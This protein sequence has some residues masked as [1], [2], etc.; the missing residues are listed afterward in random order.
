MPVF[1]K[2]RRGHQSGRELP[3]VGARNQLQVLSKSRSSHCL[4]ISPAP[5]GATLKAVEFSVGGAWSVL[6]YSGQAFEDSPH[7]W[8]QSILSLPSLPLCEKSLPRT[9]VAVSSVMPSLL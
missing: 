7:V 5:Y 9:P 6:S 3:M 4:P 1:E 2:A 8:S